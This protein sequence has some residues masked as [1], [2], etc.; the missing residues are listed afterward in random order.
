MDGVYAK[1]LSAVTNVTWQKHIANDVL[2]AGL[3][4]I[5]TTI[6]ERLL[7]FKGHCW[8]SK[9]EVVSDLVLWEPKHSKRSVGGQALTFVD[10]LEADVGVPRLLACRDGWQG[11]FEKE[12]HGGSAQF[13][14]AVVV[15]CANPQAERQKKK[16]K[17]KKKDRH[18]EACA[19]P[20]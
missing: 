2:Y 16:K 1:M 18:R 5:S 7:S 11:W 14:L 3:A 4:R 17:K 8:R 19:A 15:K 12:N 6:R 10:L 13:D 9:N 20:L